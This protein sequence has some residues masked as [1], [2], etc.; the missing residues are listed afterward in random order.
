MLRFS[1]F[2]GSVMG[3]VACSGG[4][5]PVPEVNEPPTVSLTSHQGVTSF[6]EGQLISFYAEVTDPNDD[7]AELVTSWYINGSVICEDVVP[8]EEGLSHCD[9]R[10]DLSNTTL[11]VKVVDPDGEEAEDEITFLITA[12]EAPVVAII[13]PTETGTYYSNQQISFSAV[14]SDNEDLATDLTYTLSSSIDGDLGLTASITE[15]GTIDDDILLSPGEHKLSLTVDDTMAKS[16]T[17]S[18]DIVVGEPNE[19][20]SCAIT[21][22]TSNAVY[23]F[24]DEINFTGTANDDYLESPQLIVS[25]E[26]SLD[27]VLDT[28]AP[29]I[30][31]DIGVST[32]A[33]TI[34]EHTITLS[35]TDEIQGLCSD[36][37]VVTIGTPPTVTVDSPIN[38]SVYDVGVAVPFGATVVDNE[39]VASDVTLA[40]VSDLDGEFSTQGSDSTGN[41][42]FDVSTLTLGAHNV[43]VTA[44]DTDGLTDSAS[45]VV[46]VNNAPTQPSVSIS[47]NPAQTGDDLV[48][49]A[50]GSTDA[51][52]DTVTYQ[53]QWY[54]GGVA[55]SHV[56]DTVPSADTAYG[57]IWKVRVTPYDGVS[58]GAY[59]EASLLI[60]NTAPSIDSVAIS[61]ST[62]H[63]KSVLTCTS[64]PSDPDQYITADYTWTIN[65]NSYTGDTLDLSTT[66]AM[67]NDVV[68]CTAMVTDNAG[69][70]A[71]DSASVTLN[72][73]LPV[74]DD[75]A[76]SPLTVLTDTTI[77]CNPTISDNDGETPSYTIEWA[78]NGNSIGTS[79]PTTLNS[80]I[81][82]DT[83]LLTCT[84]YASDGYGGT[85]SDSL[86]I[87]IGNDPPVVDSVSFSSVNVYTN[88][89]ITVSA[90][91]SDTDNTQPITVNY[92]WH[93][94]D[95]AT[96]VDSVVQN[97]TSNTLDGSTYF[98]RDDQVYVVVTAND[99]LM[100]G[101]SVSSSVLNIMNT[102]PTAPSVSVSPDPALEATDDLVC[103]IDV[104]S[105]DVDG[106][107]ILYTY[108]WKDEN[109]VTQQTTSDVTDLSDTF[110]GTDTT[111]GT[112]SCMVT[113]NDGTDMGSTTTVNVEVQGEGDGTAMMTD[114]TF[115]DVSYE[116]CGT[117]S[118]SSCTASA[119][120]TACTAVGKKVVSHASDGTTEVYSLGATNSCYWSVSY[121]TV[122]STMGSDECLVG[123][124]NLEWTDCCGTTRWHGNTMPFGSPGTVFGYTS[125]NTSGYQSSY[126]NS[127]GYT[128]GCV[129]E[130]NAASGYGGC[131]TYY[132]ACY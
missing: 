32:S 85:S 3:V 73:Q 108:M 70:T 43:T 118:I 113:P 84:V 9:I 132:V 44:T 33:L 88:D 56:T 105:T 121:Y 62:A 104:E 28:T 24:A 80:S 23:V 126:S 50:F 54:L 4:K 1:L 12:T 116:V 20:P 81:C 57:D 41:V 59:A 119:A 78:I 2:M 91:I 129:D 110:A 72:N 47:P 120:K 130:S 82:S 19:A 31:G 101:A 99:S 34:G 36:S 13:S 114:G 60:A 102:V 25:W 97:G 26:S 93:V 21:N 17:E 27:G 75:I 46:Y 18:V 123:I 66:T 16:T 5:E 103:S 45:F 107:S 64:N 76:I 111:A 106:D 8:D 109:D 68:T 49:S 10:F 83:D 94:I 74:I 124:S 11:S 35:V 30:D 63:N 39:D 79:N 87:M 89:V 48:A 51:D 86:T 7:F 90:S 122:D 95:F 69:E 131:S 53:Y 128:W 98:D 22:P 112:W 117:G 67:P 77:T 96:G 61:P 58:D 15:T 100:D 55:T 14:V 92:E 115:I 52:G 37:V 65:S 127:S 6:L 29:T 71:S 40:W 125:S 38:G 42:S